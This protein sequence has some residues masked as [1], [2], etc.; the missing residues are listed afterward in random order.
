M[1]ISQTSLPDISGSVIF[2]DSDSIATIAGVTSNSATIYCIDV[3]NSSNAAT[4]YTKLWNL[5]S[6]SVTV[7]T[8]APD[9]II[10]TPASTRLNIPIPKG[11][12]FGAGLSVASVTAGGTAGTTSPTSDVVVRILYV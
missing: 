8:T 11:V 3:D 9:M 5:A 1:A 6:G 7:G 10:L 2:T 12:V 4:T